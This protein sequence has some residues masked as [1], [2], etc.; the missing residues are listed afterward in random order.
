MLD[1][2][3]LWRRYKNEG[4]DS[5]RERLIEH[6][7]PLVK[8]VLGRM[9]VTP[10]VHMEH[11]DLAEAGVVGLIRAVKEFD[12]SRETRFST[13]AVPR[14]RGSILDE[15]RAQDWVPRSARRMAADVNKAYATLRNQH[16]HSPTVDDVAE[17]MHVSV[18]EVNKML[19]HTKT[20]MFSSLET[21]RDVGRGGMRER[22]SETLQ[23]TKSRLPEMDVELE[24]Q[25]RLLS[26]AI[27]RLSYQERVVVTLY[28]FKNL[29]LKEIAEVLHVS[30]PRIS[31][32]HHKAVESLRELLETGR[33]RRTGS[34]GAKSKERLSIDELFE[35]ARAISEGK[36]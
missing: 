14:I 17:V 32:I 12:P 9:P 18:G 8:Y 25:E 22:L 21:I 28:Y 33:S 35:K 1:H 5:A 20:A 16:K 6:H 24:E 13:F 29:M 31:Q 2:K 10:P 30:K 19:K 34:V 26:E 7:L 4:D 11:E 15:L 23:D 27:T 3:E 36:K